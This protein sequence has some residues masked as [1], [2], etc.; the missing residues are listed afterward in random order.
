MLPPVQLPEKELDS[1]EM[2]IE[3]IEKYGDELAILAT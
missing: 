3:A 2:I 1:V